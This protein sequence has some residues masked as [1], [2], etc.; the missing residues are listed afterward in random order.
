[1]QIAGMFFMLIAGHAL[2][3]FGFQTDS[4]A[5]GKNRRSGPPPQYDPKVHG[6]LQITWVYYMGAHALIHGLVVAAITGDWRW[7]VCETIMH[8]L[9]D[10]AKCEN[11]FGI[12]TDQFLHLV[13]KVVWAWAATGHRIV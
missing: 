5:K 11:C 1:M 4:I 10:T 6:P 8:G 9:I 2:A 7:G 3:D 13:T 12:H